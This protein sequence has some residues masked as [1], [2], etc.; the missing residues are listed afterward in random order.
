M[1]MCEGDVQQADYMLD[2]T[3]YNWFFRIQQKT[4][5]SKWMQEMIK[6]GGQ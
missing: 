6:N 4:R 1:K 2:T 5:Y 3:I